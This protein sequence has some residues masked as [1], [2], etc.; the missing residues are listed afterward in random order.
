[1][2]TAS[3][4]FLLNQW[5]YYVRNGNHAGIGYPARN[6]IHKMIKEGPGASQST[7]TIENE[8][9]D[10]FIYI[11]QCYGMM[12]SKFREVIKF[13]YVDKLSKRQAAIKTKMNREKYRQMLCQAEAGID[14]YLKA[15][16]N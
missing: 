7:A 12:N 6:V 2:L 10:D 4:E 15:K 11:D 8:V 14:Y 16:L 13:R 3:L 1:M 9:P 5:G